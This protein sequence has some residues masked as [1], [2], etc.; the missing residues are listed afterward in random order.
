MSPDRLPNT[1]LA[2]EQ[3]EAKPINRL[4][5]KGEDTLPAHFQRNFVQ[6]G[7][8]VENA[9]GGD[10]E[11]G[12][13]ALPQEENLPPSG[14]FWKMVKGLRGK[15]TEETPV[16]PVPVAARPAL[17]EDEF[18]PGKHVE[19][20]KEM[21]SVVLE[22]GTRYGISINVPSCLTAHEWEDFEE[23]VRSGELIKTGRKIEIGKKKR[24]LAVVVRTDDGQ[25]LIRVK[26]GR[27][28]LPIFQEM[29]AGGFGPTENPAR[30]QL[31]IENRS[32]LKGKTGLGVGE[33]KEEQSVEEP[34]LFSSL[35]GN[36]GVGTIADRKGVIEV[37]V[38]EAFDKRI[39]EIVEE[40]LPAIVDI[41]DSFRHT[42]GGGGLTKGEFLGSRQSAGETTFGKG[43]R[44]KVN[45]CGVQIIRPVAAFRVVLVGESGEDQMEMAEEVRK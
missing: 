5:R 20:A 6:A 15:Q 2:S 1:D 3:P 43:R 42:F 12:I 19:L 13:V 11:M 21:P 14:K 22:D 24:G 18:V 41:R 31:L 34:M 39:S 44:E 25:P 16:P 7:R 36:E 40:P 35:Q 26:L 38:Y 4:I 45:T 37:V 10:I 17:H 30:K 8:I 27:K 32:T 33:E 9:D 23:E 29:L 28:N